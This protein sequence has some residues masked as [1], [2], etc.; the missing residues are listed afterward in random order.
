MAPLGAEITGAE[1]AD[2]EAASVATNEEQR[3]QSEALTNAPTGK[4]TPHQPGTGEDRLPDQPVAD[5][6]ELLLLADPGNSGPI[7]VGFDSATVPLPKGVGLTFA[8]ENAEA[9]VA[10]AG[11]DS[12]TLHII[13]EQPEGV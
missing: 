4:M 7:M 1:D 10:S 8:V 6:K 13:G 5:G 2:G 12:D 11:N 3:R 9:F